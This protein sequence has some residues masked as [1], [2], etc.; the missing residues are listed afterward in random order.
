MTFSVAQIWRYPVKSF[1][2]EQIDTAAVSQNGIP[3][4]RYWAVQDVESKDILSARQVGV[5]MQFSA[6]FAGPPMEGHV[7]ADITFPSGDVVSTR[8]PGLDQR[9]SDVLDRE[10]KLSAVRPETDDV[11][12]KREAPPVVTPDTL[13]SDFGLEADEPLDNFAAQ[14]DAEQGYTDLWMQ[15]RSR[16]G[17]HFDTSALHILTE[18]SLDHMRRLVPDAVVD[19]RRYRPNILLTHDASVEGTVE[20][21]WVNQSLKIG[22]AELVVTCKTIRCVMSTREQGE[23]PRAAKLM[24]AL[25]KNTEQRL[26]VSVEVRA[27]G[28][29][30]VGDQLDQAGGSL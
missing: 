23:L 3:Y 6:R 1:A 11:Y 22:G 18:A 5:L 28:Q 24:R 27:P 7:Q 30:K 15:Y 29:I 19:V 9:L 12:Y 21:D 20:F 17:T 25:V 8:D 26:G 14:T 13:R 4:D 10:V 2:G 16:P